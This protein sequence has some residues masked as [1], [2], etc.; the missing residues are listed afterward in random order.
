MKLFFR[1]P[2]PQF[3]EKIN[4]LIDLAT[5]N[6]N[7]DIVHELVVAS[8]KIGQ[9]TKDRSI[10]KMMNSTLKEMRYTAKVFGPYRNRMKVTIFGSAR[11]PSD[12]P[13]YK[14][15]AR[16]AQK[17]VENDFVV[18]TGGGFGIMEAASRGAGPDSSFGI[19][20]KLPFEKIANEIIA[21]NPRMVRYKYFFNRKVAFIKETHAIALFPGGFGT[22]DEVMETLTLMQTGKQNPVPIVLLETKGN[23][24]WEKWMEFIEGGLLG[25]EYISPEDMNLFTI[26]NDE[27][28]AVKVITSFYRHYHSMRY[29]GDLVVMRLKTRLG[30]DAIKALNEEF[31]ECLVPGGSFEIRDALPEEQDE[32]ELSELPRLTFPFN[33]RSF[34]KLKII[35]ERINSF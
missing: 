32:P 9:D 6:D 8:L 19:I 24:Y 5:I 1:K 4:A 18:I 2:N 31:S 30:E 33:K 15:A 34:S 29:A 14:M 17:L 25:E 23:G 11:T 22:M 35:I 26:I 7:R 16:F 21:N 20:I 13:L 12:N 27:E 10:L 28:E 3:D